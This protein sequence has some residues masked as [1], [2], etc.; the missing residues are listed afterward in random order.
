MLKS[1]GS[2][3]ISS[4]KEKKIKGSDLNVPCRQLAFSQFANV[5]DRT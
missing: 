3:C 5:K 4:K 2:F 1:G